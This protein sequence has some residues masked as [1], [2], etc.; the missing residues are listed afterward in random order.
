[1][2]YTTLRKKVIRPVRNFLIYLVL[3]I[4]FF[5]CRALPLS[6]AISLG[7]ALGSM[8]FAV[9][10]RERDR[11]LSNIREVLTDIHSER[12]RRLLARGVFRNLGRNAAVILKVPSFSREAVAGLVTSEGLDKIDRV[13]EKRRGALLLTGHFGNWELALL[14]LAVRGYPINAVARRLRDGRFDRFVHTLRTSH[15]ATL[16]YRDEGVRRMLRALRENKLVGVLPD[17]DIKDVDTVPVVFLG[18][19]T[20]V[21]TGPV[22]LAL[23]SKSPIIPVFMVLE[24]GRYRFTIEEPICIEDTG[25]RVEMLRRYTQHWVSVVERYIRQY[26]DQ[27]IWMH[28]RWRFLTSQDTK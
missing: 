9:V 26:P 27:W 16:I 18:Q 22:Q 5:V 12:E 6:A 7:A 19:K 1:M 13:L 24:A 11:A 15:G 4:C 28:E 25:D 2:R 17:V 21:V 3:K 8:A 14:Y 20:E 10:R 23:L